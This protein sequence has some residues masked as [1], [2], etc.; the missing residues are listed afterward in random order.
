LFR[1]IIKIEKELWSRGRQRIISG[2]RTERL[3]QPFKSGNGE[4]LAFPGSGGS[5]SRYTGAIREKRNIR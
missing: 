1:D 5:E 4:I 3:F 2:K